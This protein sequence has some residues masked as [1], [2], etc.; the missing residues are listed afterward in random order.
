MQGPKIQ[1]YRGPQRGLT[2]PKAARML[3]FAATLPFHILRNLCRVLLFKEP[4]NRRD[5]II[6]YW[7][8]AFGWVYLSIRVGS[9]LIQRLS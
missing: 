2:G 5:R 3:A 8:V 7:F 4:T 1:Y 6:T 9:H